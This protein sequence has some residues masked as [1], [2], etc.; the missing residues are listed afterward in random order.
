MQRR[1]WARMSDRE[2]VKL[3]LGSVKCWKWKMLIHA[4]CH[5]VCYC[6]H[7]IADVDPLTVDTL[8]HEQVR[9]YV[10]KYM[11]IQELRDTY[12]NILQIRYVYILKFLPHDRSVQGTRDLVRKLIHMRQKICTN[13]NL[14]YCT[15]W[16]G[17]WMREC[18]DRCTDFH[19][20]R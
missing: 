14:C 6:R 11:Y 8:L 18:T 2:V 4:S 12:V 20:S 17:I 10:Y 1:T 15:F 19:A 3:K 13:I 9:V 5:I 7:R 16:T